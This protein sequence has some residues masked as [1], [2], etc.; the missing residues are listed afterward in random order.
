MHVDSDS[1]DVSSDRV[2]LDVR[3]SDLKGE[4]W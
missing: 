2:Y 1:G 3:F 4:E